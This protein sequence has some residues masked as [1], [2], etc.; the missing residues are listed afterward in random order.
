MK[1]KAKR[2]ALVLLPLSILFLIITNVSYGAY[3]F[4]ITS[5]DTL[6][7]YEGYM[8]EGWSGDTLD[9]IRFIFEENDYIRWYAGKESEEDTFTVYHE[10]SYIVKTSNLMLDDQW[11]F[12]WEGDSSR[13]T[14]VD[15]A[16]LSLYIEDRDTTV[17]AYQVEYQ[18]IEGLEGIIWWCGSIGWVQ[19]ENESPPPNILIS[20][21]IV[22]G[23]GY[24]PLQ[25]GNQWTFEVIPGINDTSPT[26][27]AGLS[28]NQNYPNPFN[29]QTM[30][31]Y[32]L[33]ENSNVKLDVYNLLG[34]HV[35]TLVNSSVK[36]GEHSISWDAS[37]MSSGIYFYKLT[38]GEKSTTKRM[39]L[40]K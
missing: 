37:D 3:T 12:W 21:N 4:E 15:T 28:L 11:N 35:Q 22:G 26:I 20:W 1:A 2:F 27:P 16:S 19:F 23:S 29:S 32:F 30:I 9:A 17:F 13:A 24:Y 18:G 10:G 5:Y 25:V 33:A 14:V 40:L 34:Q 8:M 31:S 36:A 7:G 6:D 38:T 39:V